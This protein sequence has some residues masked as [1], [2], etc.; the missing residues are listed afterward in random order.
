MSL[1]EQMQAIEIREPGGPSVL[2]TAARPLPRAETGQLLLKVHAAGVNRPDVVQRQG[3]Y[4]PP[5][6]ASDIPG[7]EVAG[8]VVAL[9]AEA[10]RYAVGDYVCALVTGGGYAE[11][12]NVD[13]AL[14]LPV[15][16]GMSMVEAAGL[17]ETFFTVWHNLFQRARLQPGENLLVHGGSS[18]I[19]ITAIQIARQL[20]VSVYVTAGSADKCVA[21]EELGANLAINYREQDF[22]A[23]LEAQ[24]LKMDVI[25]DMVGG[26]YIQRN[27]K[28]AAVDGRIVSIAFLQGAKVEV[29]FMPMLLKRLTLMASTLRAQ[30][31]AAK[32]TIAREL[33]QRVWPLLTAGT[34]KPVI[35]AVYPLA[36]AGRAH[37]RMESG[38]H[39]GKIILTLA[40]NGG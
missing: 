34:V 36:Q 14:A 32:V 17:P 35:D 21:C 23:V 16:Q 2:Q 40:A 28:A 38:C 3:H 6:G 4:P 18:G 15:P 19:G 37:E 39:I 9:G 1:P 24:N 20:G 22:V 31:L 7:L 29:N 12:V 13:E 26:D 30:P 8:E 25:L 5:P 11:Y 10:S 33:E 27:M